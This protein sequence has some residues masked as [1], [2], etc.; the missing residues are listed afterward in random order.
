M[1][2]ER[3]TNFQYIAFELC[4]ATV[5]DYVE[6]ADFDKTCI[7]AKT[8]LH[9]MMSGIAHLHSLNIGQSLSN[10]DFFFCCSYQSA[11]YL[12]MN[13]L[14]WINLH[15]TY[16]ICLDWEWICKGDEMVQKLG[17]FQFDSILFCMSCCS[18]ENQAMLKNALWKDKGDK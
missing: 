9:Q 8:L 12:Q 5:H 1:L 11:L 4:M 2:K 6:K 3:D 7:N 17:T 18:W 14:F 10:D 15:A 16:F 13:F